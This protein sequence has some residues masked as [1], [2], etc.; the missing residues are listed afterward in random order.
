MATILNSVALNKQPWGIVGD[1]FNRQSVFKKTFLGHY[2]GS[3]L[4]QLI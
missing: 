2:N 3:K 1:P 4:W